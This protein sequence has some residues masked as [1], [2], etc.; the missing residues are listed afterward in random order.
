[1]KLKALK[2]VILAFMLSLLAG[3]GDLFVGHKVTVPPATVAK[4]ITRDG[5]QDGIIR[6]S[7]FRL[8]TCIA[9]CDNLVTMDIS[10]RQDNL[11]LSV[12]MPE[13]E[14]SVDLVL[15][16]S[17]RIQPNS[18]EYLFE[19]LPVNNQSNSRVSNIPSGVAYNT[20]GR[21]VIEREARSF[22]TRYTI[23]ELMGN[24]ESITLLLREHLTEVVANETPFEII[25]AGINNI[26]YPAPIVAA[27][28]AAAERRAS[29]ATEEAQLDISRVQMARAMEEAGLQR[30]LDIARARAEVEV[31]NVLMDMVTPEYIQYRQLALLQ[32]LVNSENTKIVPLGILDSMAGQISV[33]N[34]LSR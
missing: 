21:G 8:P 28:N 17:Y 32:E 24:R 22:L 3:C 15:T 1:M 11:T 7:T 30:E 14:L 34:Q 4:I 33:G 5:Y 26:T 20:Y 19:F 16:V 10:D 6:P 12:F 27:Q 31:N 18:Y 23:R 25:N 13:D 29:V 2:V 9:Y